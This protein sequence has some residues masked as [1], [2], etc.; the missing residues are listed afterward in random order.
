MD[1]RFRTIRLYIPSH[2][3]DFYGDL[4][5]SSER[6]IAIQIVSVDGR[7]HHRP[8]VVSDANL[9]EMSVLWRVSPAESTVESE[10]PER[11]Y[12]L[13][14]AVD[15]ERACVSVYTNDAAR[16]ERAVENDTVINISIHGVVLSAPLRN[17]VLL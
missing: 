1:E 5:G 16:E 12:D 2:L 8:A 9:D 4:S 14:V 17:G 13:A 6:A 10:L 3:E 7:S 15:L 11:V